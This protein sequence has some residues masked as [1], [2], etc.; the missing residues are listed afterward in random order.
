MILFGRRHVHNVH[1]RHVRLQPLVSQG[2][3]DE[4]RLKASALL[5][6]VGF[7]EGLAGP[8]VVQDDDA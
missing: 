3:Y 8:A 5:R 2:E 1:V 6:A 4:M 7:V